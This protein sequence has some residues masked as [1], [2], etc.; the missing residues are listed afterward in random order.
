MRIKYVFGIVVCICVIAVCAT[1]ITVVSVGRDRPK[2]AQSDGDTT[3]AVTTADRTNTS[4]PVPEVLSATEN[5]EWVEI[6]TTVGAFHYPTA[7]ADILRVEAVSHGDA[8]AL[9]FVA[10]LDERD[11]TVYTIHYNKAVGI[12]CGTWKM[13][14]TAEEIAV[15]ADLTETTDGISADWLG[16]FYAAQETFNDVLSSMAEDSRFTRQEGA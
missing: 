12:R 16:T 5:G 3:T 8:A 1:V 4:L 14:D 10:R 7:L 2:P 13:S 9:Q 15:Y 6:E 11:V